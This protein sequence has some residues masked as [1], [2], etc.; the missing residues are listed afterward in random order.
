MVFAHFPPIVCVSIDLRD[1]F[2]PSL[3][4]SIMLIK[5][6]LRPLSCSS[7]FSEPTVGRV[8]GPP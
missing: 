7:R 3:R 5:D 2:I 8:S 6:I 1:V 4:T